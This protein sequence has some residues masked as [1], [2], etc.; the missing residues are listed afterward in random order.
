M[1]PGLIVAALLILIESQLIYALVPQRTR[2]YTSVLLLTAAGWLLGQLWVGIG[3]PAWR[4]G[5]ADVFPAFVFAL[6]L[7]PAAVHIPAVR[8]LPRFGGGNRGN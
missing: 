1:P 7:Q 6:L 8:N 5:Q 4:I 3:W 2:P